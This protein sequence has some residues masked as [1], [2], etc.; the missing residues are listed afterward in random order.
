MIRC[1]VRLERKIAQ[2]ESEKKAICER[3]R[4]VGNEMVAMYDTVYYR[5]ADVELTPDGRSMEDRQRKTQ[6][7]VP[8]IQTLVR[9]RPGLTIPR[10]AGNDK[11]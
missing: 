7:D 3:E 5:H 1:A 10:G 4:E 8:A 9:V 6:A 2:L 11:T